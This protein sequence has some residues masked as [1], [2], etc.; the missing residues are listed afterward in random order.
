M[1]HRVHCIGC[2]ED[3]LPNSYLSPSI[4]EAIQVG[5]RDGDM[6]FFQ[7]LS[8]TE[9]SLPLPV[10]FDLLPSFVQEDHQAEESVRLMTRALESGQQGYLPI[11]C[12][13]IRSTGK[14]STVLSHKSICISKFEFCYSTFYNSEKCETKSLLSFKYSVFRL[15]KCVLT[16]NNSAPQNKA[17]NSKMQIEI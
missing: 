11:T 10:D 8:G 7:G 5:R 4:D 3:Q 17:A 15:I 9:E 6:D 2:I 1:D 13:S 12:A 14:C 16:R